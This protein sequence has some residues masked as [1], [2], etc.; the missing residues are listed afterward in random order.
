MKDAI[1]EIN[2]ALK[3]PSEQQEKQITN[4]ILGRMMNRVTGYYSE[5]K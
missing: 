5:L 1:S 3:G 2:E 4:P